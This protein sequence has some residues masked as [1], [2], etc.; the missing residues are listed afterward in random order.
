M[1]GAQL[2]NLAAKYL[3]GR[4]RL[5]RWASLVPETSFSFPSRNPTAAAL[6]AAVGFLR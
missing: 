6:A 5:A 4:A 2:L 1:G 3:L